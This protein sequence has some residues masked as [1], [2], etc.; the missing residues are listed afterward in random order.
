MPDV[1]VLIP[2]QANL[3]VTRGLEK[4]L[5]LTRDDDLI[6]LELSVVCRREG[7]SLLE[8][9]IL[10]ANR[11]GGRSTTNIRSAIKMY[12]GAYWMYRS[13]RP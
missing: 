10:S 12:S 13:A 9:P 7:Y 6:D 5:E 4:H 8:V 1:D 11:H 3:R 2:H